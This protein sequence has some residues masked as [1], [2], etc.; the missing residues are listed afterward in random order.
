M[1]VRLA[2][3][4]EDNVGPFNRLSAS[5]VN[6]Y[7]SC[8]RLWFYEKVRR[9]KMPQI[10]VLFVGRAV[11]EAICRMLMESPALLVSKASSDTLSAIPLDENGVPSRSSLDPW[12]A[13]RLLA[14]PENML[15]TDMAG[16]K[17]WAIGRLKVHLHEALNS[18]KREWE[19]DE[20]RAGDWN[21]VNPD[22]CL[23]MCING[24]QF[25]LN[26]V[27]RCLDQNGGPGLK[28]WRRG[29]RPE[30]P[31]PD[32]RRYTL[33]NNHPLSRNGEVSLIEAW[34]ISRPWFVDPNA[35]K[36]AMNA[37]H[38][39]HWFQGEYDLVYRWDGRINI[40]DLKASIGRG[41]RSGN[42]VQQLR[43][44]AMLWWTTHEKK[45]QV[46]ALEI[47]YLGADS[48]KSIPCPTV[49]E[50]TQMEEEL[51][52]MWHQLREETPSL[53]ECPPEPAPVRGYKDGGVAIEAPNEVRC[54]RCDW[55]SIC[56]GGQGND[57]LPEGGSIQLP[58]TSNAF[59]LTPIGELDPRMTFVAEVFSIIGVRKGNRPQIT[60]SQG[61]TFAKVILLV[62][63]H[64]D[65]EPSWPQN[66]AKG[67]RIK[68]D[69]VIPSA[70]WKGEIELKVDPH[71]CI[72]HTSEGDVA[73][74]FMDFRARWNVS[75][76]LIYRFEKRGVGRNGKEWHRKGAMILD[77]T[78]AMKVEGWANDWGPQYDL[79]E[80]GDTVVVANIG[81]DAWA[82]EIR[83]NISRNTKI[84]ITERVERD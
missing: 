8:P 40:V 49:Q 26:E 27:Q 76:R 37:V 53:A 65:G 58:G 42:Y 36:F 16:L 82:V 56:P 57:Q 24:L 73:S 44:Y 38:P 22:Y 15:P 4:S 29:V 79:A 46:D 28:E 80:I 1:P 48:I 70:N 83:G 23:Q 7:R 39:E 62:D 45:Q 55:E 67:D 64:Q 34:E 19:K 59:D 9:F 63:Q 17:N 11:E 43:M 71:A 61:N 35:G 6:T 84:H 69:N 30:W 75:G 14:L 18:M 2:T 60:V 21:S 81:L 78:G 41:D 10:P 52:S 5:Q 12:P 77:A 72:V 13:E 33:S 31:S 3:P 50:M 68:L 74:D 51:E 66:L 20:R 32:A 25:H 47:W 54:S